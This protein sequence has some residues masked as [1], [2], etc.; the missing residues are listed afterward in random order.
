MRSTH[1]LLKCATE[2]DQFPSIYEHNNI[3]QCIHQHK[4]NNIDI[5]KPYIIV[6]T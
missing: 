5:L 3:S 2:K 6:L 4:L 1:C